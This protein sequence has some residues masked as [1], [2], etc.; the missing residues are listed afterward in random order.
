MPKGRKKS[1]RPE[2]LSR[3]VEV[4]AVGLGVSL[5]TRDEKGS[6]ST[7]DGYGR[8]ELAGQMD[9]PIRGTTDVRIT[10][11][12]TERATVG[13][14]PVPW[15]GLVHGSSPWCSRPS[16]FQR[17]FSTERGVSPQLAC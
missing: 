7:F 2:I 16:S 13:K 11:Y 12:S 1:G 14:E 3:Q 8:L 6:E 5:H 17:R 10:L 15:I 4:V 9:E